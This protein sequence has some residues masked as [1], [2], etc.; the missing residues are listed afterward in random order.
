MYLHGGVQSDGKIVANWPAIVHNDLHCGN[1]LFRPGG[2]A[3]YHDYPTVV[4]ADF[5]RA[6]T[7]GPS[8]TRAEVVQYQ[9]RDINT[10]GA[11]VEMLALRVNNEVFGR[12][13]AAAGE[14]PT[15]KRGAVRYDDA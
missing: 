15:P 10:F 6:I 5:D 7:E 4:I 1:V 12:W 3:D 9:R 13:A 14:I 8:K 2:Q 11:L